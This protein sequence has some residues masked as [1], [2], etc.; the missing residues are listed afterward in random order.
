M[1]TRRSKQLDNEPEIANHQ[2]TFENP[3]VPTS[4]LRQSDTIL[5]MSDTDGS[6]ALSSPP[7]SP[8]SVPQKL[9]VFQRLVPSVPDAGPRSHYST[10]RFRQDP[11]EAAQVK[12]QKRFNNDSDGEDAMIDEA[13]YS[14]RPSLEDEY[15]QI[16]E[17][18]E[19]SDSLGRR[20]R[21]DV[22]TGVLS[23]IEA[24]SPDL[25]LVN[26]R[27]EP[28]SKRKPPVGERVGFQSAADAAELRYDNARSNPLAVFGNSHS[29]MR[30]PSGARLETSSPSSG[31]KGRQPKERS[32]TI[33]ALRQYEE[34]G[35]GL[36]QAR[37]QRP[38]TRDKSSGP[39][40]LAET[41]FAA[42]G[43]ALYR[44]DS[45][46]GGSPARSGRGGTRG[47]RGR[48]GAKNNGSRGGGN[49]N[50][51]RGRPKGKR[52][53]GDDDPEPP[54]RKSL[55]E[56]EEEQ[57]RRLKQRQQEL[58]KLF[59]TVGAHQTDLLDLLASRDLNKLIKKARAHTKVPEYEELKNNLKE[60]MEAERK[61]T[62]TKYDV[63]SAAEMER[64]EREKELIE[65]PIQ[66]EMRRNPYG[67]PT[68]FAG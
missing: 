42:D 60:L 64:Y 45:E 24:S 12:R 58:K 40:K 49:G 63:A 35:K 16:T 4:S 43:E 36:T 37:T 2:T 51:G 59:A 19:A 15:K 54:Q 61:V 28:S 33:S 67:A 10:G 55:T 13:Y 31:A 23:T 7:S 14:R 30:K 1:R 66:T 5:T 44:P 47:G 53:G 22:G 17:A 25:A 29:D 8:E 21:R 6:S 18:A 34:S 41:H 27:L 62:R 46:A 26:S 56:E 11:L 9:G 3:V 32:K 48:G 20:T 65:T 57:V 68:R 38:F 52:G 50:G 39:R